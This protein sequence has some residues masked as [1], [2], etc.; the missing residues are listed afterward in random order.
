MINFRSAIADVL[1]QMQERSYLLSL[2]AGV[3]FL[4]RSKI[5]T[6]AHGGGGEE[7]RIVRVCQKTRLRGAFMLA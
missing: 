3:P 6:F 2:V 7:K 1:V 5:Y 4:G